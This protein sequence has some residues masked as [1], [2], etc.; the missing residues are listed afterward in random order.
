MSSCVGSWFRVLWTISVSDRHKYT[1]VCRKT[2]HLSDVSDFHLLS[3]VSDFHLCF[4]KELRY[5]QVLNEI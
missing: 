1:V 4:G 2:H 3:D 5:L